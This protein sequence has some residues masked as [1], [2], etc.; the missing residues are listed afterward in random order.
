MS[1]RT[2]ARV[3][4]CLYAMS[5]AGRLLCASCSLAL[6][7]R[8]LY[9]FIQAWLS[10]FTAPAPATS[11]GVSGQGKVDLP[12]C[13]MCFRAARTEGNPN[14]FTTHNNIAHNIAQ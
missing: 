3:C 8:E 1:A 9:V 14:Y 13:A 11:N 5:E 6:G 12:E 4:V 2:A 7:M 10:L